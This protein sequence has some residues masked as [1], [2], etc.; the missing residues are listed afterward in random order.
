MEK[1]PIEIV[2]QIFEKLNYKDQ[3]SLYL[4][5]K[6]LYNYYKGLSSKNETRIE[7][8]IQVETIRCF[9]YISY[10]E[11]FNSYKNLYTMKF[12]KIDKDKIEFGRV[13]NQ[14]MTQRLFNDIRRNNLD[15]ENEEIIKGEFKYKKVEVSKIIEKKWSTEIKFTTDI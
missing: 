6:T 14:K 8:I 7:W 5:N 13:L 9:S 10:E 11:G 1:L 15:S 4:V 3:V 12:I 2:W